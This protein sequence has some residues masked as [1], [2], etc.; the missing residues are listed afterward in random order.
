MRKY[1]EYIEPI[2]HINTCAN[3]RAGRPLRGWP[4][5]PY[6]RIVTKDVPTY[7]R[8]RKTR[9]INSVICNC[10]AR[11][12]HVVLFIYSPGN[13]D[14]LSSLY[15]IYFIVITNQPL[16]SAHDVYVLYLY[17]RVYIIY[18]IRVVMS[19]CA[20]TPIAGIW[21][22]FRILWAVRGCIYGGRSRKIFTRWTP[23]RTQLQNFFELGV[24]WFTANNCHDAKCM[25]E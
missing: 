22:V 5:S 15:N 3:E 10:S 21:R 11:T 2:L 19:T 18:V 16:R 4:S 17:V 8:R 23:A 14:T 7:T 6:G 13:R 25:I 20:C 9:G 12:G 1:S 24:C